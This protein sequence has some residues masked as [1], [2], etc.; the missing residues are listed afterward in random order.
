[1]QLQGQLLWFLHDMK[2]YFSGW[3]DLPSF[4]WR[5]R[6]S[7]LT[8]G[9]SPQQVELSQEHSALCALPASGCKTDLTSAWLA[10]GDYAMP[11]Y[12]G[13]SAL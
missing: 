3:I 8:T 1:M 11:Q 10:C 13:S 7:I 5:L 12:A 2:Q 9:K 4:Q 6:W